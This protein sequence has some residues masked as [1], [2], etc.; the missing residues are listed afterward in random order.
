MMRAY[1]RQRFRDCARVRDPARV[2][3]MLRYGSGAVWHGAVRVGT[4]GLSCIVRR[5]GYEE[6]DRMNEMH[7]VRRARVRALRMAAL[8]RVTRSMRCA[9]RGAATAHGGT[10]DA[11]GA[12]AAA[13]VRCVWLSA[14]RQGALLPGV[15]HACVRS[16]GGR[17]EWVLAAT[18][19][20]R[21]SDR[22]AVAWTAWTA[23]AGAGRG[24]Q[25]RAV[26]WTA[27]AGAGRDES[28]TIYGCWQ[29]QRLLEAAGCNA[30]NTQQQQKQQASTRQCG[31]RQH[32]HS[33]RAGPPACPRS[34]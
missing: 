4:Q 1:V 13:A 18:V 32:A 28:V 34:I 5:E 12:G 30:S 15:R 22:R 33:R 29:L 31:C 26:A 3:R 17:M 8:R 27:R 2:Q 25:G 10:G 9:G 21:A 11:A 16:H 23:W 7:A 24:G 14:A 19:S 6:L 20:K